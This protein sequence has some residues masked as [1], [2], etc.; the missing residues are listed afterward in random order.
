MPIRM[1]TLSLL[2]VASPL[3]VPPGSAY[4]SPSSLPRADLRT[5]ARRNATGEGAVV[6]ESSLELLARAR[7]GD[8]GA[9]EHLCARYVPRLERWATGRLPPW[10]RGLVNT[11]DLVQDVLLQTVRRLDAF[12]PRHEGAFQ[13]YLGRAL[14]NRISE[15]KR[16]ARRNPAATALPDDPPDD[17][18][19]PIERI[20]GQE[21]LER[22]EAAL[23]RLRPADRAAIRLRVEWDYNYE[24]IARELN[25]PS[26]NAARMAVVRAI[27]RLAEEIRREP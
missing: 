20:V 18:P 7:A 25:K 23:E 3:Q 6:F 10:A 11:D 5:M 4:A 19:S 1:V 22:Y 24:E 9:L 14:S 21:A 15:V 12:E 16:R 26:W 8:G 27:E 17:S 13:A 2:A